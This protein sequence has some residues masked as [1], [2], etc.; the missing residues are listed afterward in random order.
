MAEF[1]VL[2]LTAPQAIEPFVECGRLQKARTPDLYRFGYRIVGTDIVVAA[3]EIPARLLG[4]AIS[5]NMRLSCRLTPDGDVVPES[6]FEPSGASSTGASPLPLDQLVRATL[7]PQN[8][9]LEEATIANLTTMLRRLEE[10]ADIVRDA[11]DRCAE[12]AKEHHVEN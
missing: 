3:I 11:L 7:T 9:H 4:E 2:A 12:T 1:T 6:S 5:S 8:L 10:S